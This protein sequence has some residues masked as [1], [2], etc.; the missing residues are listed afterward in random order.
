VLSFFHVCVWNVMV[1]TPYNNISIH[2]E[3]GIRVHLD[4][5]I[6]MLTDGAGTLCILRISHLC[7]GEFQVFVDSSSPSP[8]RIQSPFTFGILDSLRFLYRWP[9]QNFTLFYIFFL[10]SKG[11]SSRSTPLNNPA[12]L[13]LPKSVQNINDIYI[14]YSIRRLRLNVPTFRVIKINTKATANR[15]QTGT[16]NLYHWLKKE[17]SSHEIWEIA[18]IQECVLF[19]VNKVSFIIGWQLRV[20]RSWVDTKTLLA[21]QIFQTNYQ[22]GS[23]SRKGKESGKVEVT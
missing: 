3:I 1:I 14:G 10:H 19:L 6:Q 13:A 23:A 18:R 22:R 12:Q 7:V 20:V 2:M 17:R 5:E 21:M 16:N 8:S 4:L 15:A 9:W 11:P